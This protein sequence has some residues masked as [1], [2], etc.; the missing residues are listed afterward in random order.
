MPAAAKLGRKT[1]W[2]F[3]VMAL[4]ATAGVTSAA[5]A[6]EPVS[7]MTAPLYQRA[8]P[9][10]KAN[11]VTPWADESSTAAQKYGFTT[12]LG[13]P[14]KASTSAVTGLTSVHRLF[15]SSSADFTWALEGS[16]RL[17]NAVNAGY[18]DEGTNFYAAATQLAGTEPVNSYVSGTVHRLWLGSTASGL[19]SQGWTAEGAAFYVPTAATSTPPPIV[20][21]PPSTTGSP[22][23]AT[24]GTAAY[25]LPAGAVYVSP[26][27]ND[28]APGSAAAPVR[29]IARAVSVAPAGG[30]VVLRAGRYH[31]TVTISGKT[32]TVQNYPGE[33]A[34]LDGSEPVTGWVQDGSTWRHDGWSTRFD[35]SPTYTRGAP[36]STTPQWQFVNPS[37]PMAAYPDQVFVDGVPLQQ[38]ASRSQ[39]TSGTFYLDEGTSQLFIGSDPRGRTLEASTLVKAMSVRSAG[40]VLRGFGIR[41]FSPSVPDIASVTVEAPKVRLENVT[42]EDAATTGLGVLTTDGSSTTSPFAAPECSASM[43]ASPTVS[44]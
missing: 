2:L 22:G 13:T 36:D 18:Q 38:V 3:T 9:T 16:T 37:H 28:T 10:T 14:F 25:P 1:I 6:G 15:R 20:P 44:R 24:V 21:N 19:A 29:T 32:L 23:A 40:T 26:T 42:V 43:R 4:A 31:E 39:V 33:A 41:R 11:L 27:G 12:D 34:W 5:A 17:A 30:T 7:A 35:H 8:N